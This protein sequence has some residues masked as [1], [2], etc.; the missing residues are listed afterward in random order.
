MRGVDGYTAYTQRKRNHNP[1]R[2]NPS[3]SYIHRVNVCALNRE[4]R[5]LLGRFRPR[6]PRFMDSCLLCTALYA[7]LTTTM[8][9]FKGSILALNPSVPLYALVS[10]P[11]SL[12]SHVPEASTA[13]DLTSQ[14]IPLRQW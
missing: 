14:E 1:E 7:Q 10:G 8:R 13:R 9:L 4:L 2:W 5:A 3:P 6:Q 11:R 12:N